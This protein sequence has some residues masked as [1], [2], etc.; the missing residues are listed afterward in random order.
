MQ[1]TNAKNTNPP[2][3]SSATIPR[4][5][6]PAA[7]AAVSPSSKLASS[8]KVTKVS[9][10]PQLSALWAAASSSDDE[11]EEPVAV[12]PAPPPPPP[13]SKKGKYVKG[14]AASKNKYL[15]PR[16]VEEDQAEE[17]GGNDSSNKLMSGAP[18]EFGLPAGTFDAFADAQGED[19]AAAAG[20]YYVHVRVQQ[21]NG[22]KT[23]TTVQGI[24]G[25]YNYA[26]VLRDL[27]RELC[28]NGTVVEDK[29]LGKIIQLQGD[30]RNSVSDF[31]AKAGMVH[32]DNIKV[33]GF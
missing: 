19:A 29:E 22:R 13:A 1:K 9:P 18:E 3:I 28:C 5:K 7:A 30:H 8:D 12:V 6:K 11:E 20:D 16:R 26:K 25:E 32:K 21:R 15:V 17:G 31:L 10:P 27:K 23:L 33:H 2:A 14:R 4:A 24:G